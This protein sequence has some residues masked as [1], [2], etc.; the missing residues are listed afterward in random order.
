MCF[1]NYFEKNEKRYFWSVESGVISILLCY[2]HNLLIVYSS[3]LLISIMD[4]LA[5]NRKSLN[6][7][8]TSTK[9]NQSWISWTGSTPRKKSLANHAIFTNISTLHWHCKTWK[10]IHPW[11]CSKAH[12]LNF[13]VET[14]P[15]QSRYPVSSTRSEIYIIQICVSKSFSFYLFIV[16]ITQARIFFRMTV[17]K[18]WCGPAFGIFTLDF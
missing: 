11:W 4:T 9:R 15:L 6:I 17:L 5:S 1:K 13:L 8:R 14:A 2:F 10:S 12:N 18:H 16:L 3:S 7:W